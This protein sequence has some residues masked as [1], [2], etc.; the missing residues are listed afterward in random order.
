MK[1]LLVLLAMMAFGVIVNDIGVNLTM[2]YLLFNLLSILTILL[3]NVDGWFSVASRV[4]PS[5]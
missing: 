3:I 1:T 5:S 4:R 2:F